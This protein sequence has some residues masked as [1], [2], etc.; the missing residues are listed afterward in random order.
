MVSTVSDLH[1][2]IR[3]FIHCKCVLI[4][5][6]PNRE[7][8]V[9][10]VCY[11][12]CVDESKIY[13]LRTMAG[14]QICYG[15]GKEVAEALGIPYIVDIIVQHNQLRKLLKKPRYGDVSTLALMVN[16]VNV[17]TGITDRDRAET[18]SKL[19]RVASLV[20]E[21]RI[22]E[23]RQ[24]FYEGFY[25]PGHVP[26]LVANDIRKRKGHTELAIAFARLAKLKPSVAFAE[27]LSY[28]QSMSFN[29]A[30]NYAEKHEL[31]LITG[32]EILGS[33][34]EG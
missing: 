26:I 17:K 3:D 8:E 4:Y 29:E 15:V 14:G 33:I 25:V 11:A 12:E 13:M 22:E 1:R 31:Q 28:G 19:H 18:I 9:D 5:D 32:D 21:G 7:D 24:M 27:M 23:A 2:A 30:K 16:S 10:M 34:L 20:Y 6:W